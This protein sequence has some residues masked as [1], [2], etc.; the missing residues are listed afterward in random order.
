M[1]YHRISRYYPGCDGTPLAVDLYLPASEQPVPVIFQVTN[2][3][4]RAAGDHPMAQ[5]QAAEELRQ[6]EFWLNHGYAVCKLEPRGVGA[7]YGVSEGFWCPKD[8][9]D[10]K[11]VIDA[12]AAEPWCNGNAGMYGGSNVGASQHF[13]AMHQPEHLRCIIPCD[14]SADFYYQNYPN[15]VSIMPAVKMPKQPPQLGTPVDD[16]PA[17]DYPMA[18]E[19]LDCHA[20]N[21]GFLEQY[22]PHMHRDEVNPKIGYAPN[23]EIPIWEKMDTVRYGHVTP[24][25][26]GAWFDPGCTNKIFEFKRWGGKLLLGPWRHCEVYRGESDLPEGA[27]DWMADHLAFFEKHLKGAD[28]DVMAM[29]PVRY[30]TLGDAEPW[31]FAADFPLDS[32]TNPQ[33]RLSAAGALLDGP[34]EAGTVAYQVRDDIHFFDSMGRL[35]RRIEKDLAPE[36]AKCLCF[37]TAPLEK[38]LEL[39]GFPVVE[40]YVTSTHTDGIF[41]AE[42]EEITPDGVCHGITEGMIRGRSAAIGRNP[43]TD[44]LG[45]PYH[46]S[47]R[48]DDVQLS[49][50]E[51]TLLAFHLE[52]TSRILKAGSRLC[53][54]VSCGGN[55][56]SQ[57]EDM[58][59]DV[60]VTFHFGGENDALLRLPVIAPNVTRF[61]SEDAAEETEM[62]AFK[63]AVYRRTAAGWE[64]YPCRQVFPAADGTHFVTEAFT[65]LRRQEGSCV[66]LT[67]SDGPFA[68]SGSG[69]LPDRMTFREQSTEIVR[70]LDPRMRQWMQNL[71]RVTPTF[72]NLYVA[73]VP[74]RREQPGQMNPQPVNTFDLFVDLVLPA[75]EGPF[76][77]IVQIHGFGGNNHQFEAL[78][79]QLLARGYACASIDYRLMPPNVWPSSGE[80]A[81][82]CIRYLKANAARLHLD[83][84]RFG[85]MGGSMGGQL[86]AM[87][88]ACNGDPACE[89][90]IGGITDQDCAVR[91]AVALFAPTDLFTFGEDCAAVWPHQPDKVANGDGPYAPI[92]SMLGW[93]GPGRGMGDIK[94]HLFDA[95]PTY[96]A[97][98]ALAKEASPV[99]HVTERSAPT[100]LVHGIAECGIQVPMGQSLRMF[101]ALTRKG[102]KSLLLCNNN[103]LFGA[104]PE[105]AAAM[106]D[107]LCRRV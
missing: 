50:T 7:S 35:N 26:Y 89:G 45:V 20:L 15:G 34:A 80:D 23:M 12:V 100:C 18:H 40:L 51:P 30:Y 10:M 6:Y 24:Y 75:G 71:A 57:P 105:V 56:F 52:A 98:I 42:L 8:G 66:T 9:R 84:A 27:F 95:D 11:A 72:H 19:A 102:V 37:T 99:Y 44:A 54:A 13:A 17:P 70:T 39:T 78:T 90:D 28:N 79:P 76:P 48:R 82:A 96:Q 5:A 14:C 59:E 106:L 55:Q 47:L 2:G 16:D 67:V 73:T 103:G 94:H 63:R 4:R 38:D 92:A 46:T 3:P 31:H 93:T 43:A 68:F 74:C 22:T 101:E 61:R 81:R 41:L 21:M 91:A 32:Q 69:T 53:L 29:P 97:L 62:Y 87:L 25:Q 65:A 88:A 33:L 83:P 36:N 85:L 1:T 104:D 64:C 60:T 49:P 77:C 58:P 107:F 86:T